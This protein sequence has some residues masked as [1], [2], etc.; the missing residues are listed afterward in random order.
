[1]EEEENVIRLGAELKELILIFHLL[2]N[3]QQF[4]SEFTILD[5]LMVQFILK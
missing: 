3:T 4:L 2:L 5:T 1:M